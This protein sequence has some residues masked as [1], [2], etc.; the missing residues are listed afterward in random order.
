[1]IRAGPPS[2]QPGSDTAAGRPLI[3]VDNVG[4]DFFVNRNALTVFESLSCRIDNG[5]FVSVVGPSGCGKSTLLK[6]ISGLEPPTRGEVLFNGRPIAGPA[7]GM[8]YVFQQYAKSIF[9]WR[10]VIENVAFGLASHKKLGRRAARARC[11]EYIRLVGL[12][13]YE[14]Y[15]PYQLSGGMQQRVC[16]AR[17]LICEPAVL[18]MDEPFS[19]VDALTRAILQE[20]ILKI[21]QAIPVTVVFVTHDVEEAIFLSSRVLSLS[22]TP[23]SI[24]QDIAIDLPYPR[25]QIRTREDARFTALRHRLFSS[26][27]LQEKAGESGS[28][29]G[30][31]SEGRA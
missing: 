2:P 21:W 4:K 17:A 24:K 16:I 1:M 31:P 8:I 3:E 9:P 11:L 7:K 19:A 6:L 14:D 12:D 29:S 26:I 20:L 13:G 25:D 18:L 15:F 22:K 28:P 10:T 5:S 30:P 27:F 23:A